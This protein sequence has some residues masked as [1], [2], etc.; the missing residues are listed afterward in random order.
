M[1][2]VDDDFATAVAVALATGVERERRGWIFEKIRKKSKRD[3]FE[4]KRCYAVS[5]KNKNQRS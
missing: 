3:S 4:T 2:V 1:D 5:P